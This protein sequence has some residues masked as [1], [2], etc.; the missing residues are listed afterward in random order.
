MTELV[1][2][3]APHFQDMER[4]ATLRMQGNTPTVIAKATGIQRKRVIEL[5]EE[6]NQ[7]V[8]ASKAGADRALEAL[9][10]MDMHYDDLIKKAYQSLDEIQEDLENHMT[11]QKMQQ[12]LNAIKLIAELEKNRLDALQKAGLLDAADMGDQVAEMEEKQ[13]I[14]IEILRN[15]LCSECKKAVGHKLSKV[16]QKVEPVVVYNE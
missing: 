4:V 1:L 2:A 13:H 11:P 16:T 6:F 10:N 9:N 15:D 14:L 8:T 7:T 5:L 3:D 12:K